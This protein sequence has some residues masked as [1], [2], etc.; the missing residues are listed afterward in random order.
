MLQLGFYLAS[1]GMLR[2]SSTVLRTGEQT[3][4]QYSRAKIID[5]IFFIEGG[6]SGLPGS[7][8]GFF[9]TIG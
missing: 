2:G 4:R 8:V 5:M 3:S 9:G 7:D 1:W 6:G